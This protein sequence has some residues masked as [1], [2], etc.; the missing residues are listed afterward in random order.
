MSYH[1]V[2]PPSSSAFAPP[3]A[4]ADYILSPDG[5]L[6]GVGVDSSDSRKR[7][8]DLLGD[9]EQD[10]LEI[11]PLGAG[12][13]VGRSC[14]ILK[15]KGKTIML[16]CG[17]HPAYTG[18]NSLPYFDEIDPEEIDLILVTHFHLD[19]AAAL[20]YFLEK[21]SFNGRC[22]MTHPTKSVYKLILQDY[23]K[24]SMISVEE[25]LYTEEDLLN[26][27]DKIECV[28]FHQVVHHKGIKFWAYNAG[29]VLGAAMFMIEIAGVRILYTG[30]YSRREDRHLMCAETPEVKPDVLIIEG[31][32]GVQRLP[33]VSEREKRFT[34]IVTDIVEN[35]HGKCLLPVFALGRAQELLLILDEYWEAH[36]SLHSIPIYYASALAK[37]CMIVYQ[38]YINMMNKRIQ[39]TAQ[40]SNPF[41][42]KHIFNLRNAETL[43]VSN[44]PQIDDGMGLTTNNSNEVGPCVVM[45]SPGMLQNGLSRQLLEAWAADPAN[46]CVITGY[47]V[48]GTLAKHIMTEPTHI[49][50]MYG[51]KVPLNMSVTYISFSAHADYTETSE[52]IDILKPQHVILVHGDATEGVGRLRHALELK[53]KNDKEIK[54]IFTPRNCQTVEIVFKQA[55]IAKTVGTLASVPPR[56]GSHFSGLL[57][58]KEHE[59]R[60]LAPSDLTEY[61]TLSSNTIKQQLTV[62]FHQ[63][64]KSLQFFVGRLFE[65]A[66]GTVEV[67]TT[68]KDSEQKEANADSNTST[69]LQ[70]LSIQNSVLLTHYPGTHVIVSWESNPVADMLADSVVAVLANVQ[71]NPGAAK[72]I[73]NEHAHDCKHAHAHKHSRGE[74]TQCTQSHEHPDNQHD[75]T[76]S[77]SSASTTSPSSIATKEAAPLPDPSS[78]I[79]VTSSSPPSTMLSTP[80]FLLPTKG[81]DVTWFLS[82]HYG[83]LTRINEDE[84]KVEVNNKQV[85]INTS[86]LDVTCDDKEVRMRVKNTLLRAHAAIFPIQKIHVQDVEAAEEEQEEE[87][88]QEQQQQQPVTD[89]HELEENTL[90]ATDDDTHDDG[91][92][93][94]AA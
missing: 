75:Q 3:P 30:D 24:V 60:L 69:T 27:M 12:S 59:Y 14:H 31:T 89:G 64:F 70:T 46:G 90:T 49:D 16:D 13:E 77:P 71:A 76:S 6:S 41:N 17:L 37:K 44:R 48:E 88:E 18:M 11:T 94:E 21:T 26:S 58:R 51:G 32:Y 73:G 52:F 15:F 1:A 80:S 39:A 40:I 19:H 86:T 25:T 68:K 43:G 33:H 53:Y 8:R 82:Q 4:T 38:R 2:P 87:N 91:L 10:T 23:V 36:P 7:V 84:W 63:T 78:S 5:I 92:E 67:A 54:N 35:R 47:C 56:D 65:V 22:F 93:D 9:D 72:I 62:P 83:Q 85:T 61:T 20:P 28:N 81:P 50:S 34:E 45:A 55:K 79:P 42:F 74:T 57:V 29:H 66:E